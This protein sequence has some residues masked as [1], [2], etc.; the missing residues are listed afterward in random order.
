[1]Q[2][3]LKLAFRSRAF[4]VCALL[5][6]LGAISLQAS[7][8][9]LE[10][11]FRKEA[12]PLLKPLK[13]LDQEA[14]APYTVLQKRLLQ[15]EEEESL[16]TTEYVNW[17][18]EDTSAEPDDP[19]RLVHLFI[20]YYTGLPDQVPHVPDVC[21]LGAG[22]SPAG[23]G[24]GSFD[25]PELAEYGYDTRVPYRALTFIKPGDV[26]DIRPVVVY[27]FG[28]NNVLA[29]ERNRVRKEMASIRQRYAYFSKVE[30]SFGLGP[31]QP[32]RDAAV[33]AAKKMLRK[34]LP[35]LISQH[36]PDLDNLEAAEEGRVRP[37]HSAA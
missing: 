7:A 36:W 5:L 27:T 11:Y 26:Q 34:V 13:Y 22:Y 18:M 9:W 30:L 12:A 6:G 31:E 17:I 35:L 25:M 28:V 10:M 8:R 37:S 29:A 20:T 23:G 4:L 32:S 14:L 1:M 3:A 33:E 16:G 15:P 2:D 24:A 19:G 21:Y